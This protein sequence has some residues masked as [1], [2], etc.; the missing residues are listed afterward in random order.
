MKCYPWTYED[1]VALIG[2]AS[3]AIVPFYGQRMNSGLKF[4]EMIEKYG[5]DWKTIFSEL[6]NLVSPMLMQ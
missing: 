6:K 4:P 3:H 2:D 5:D 1:K